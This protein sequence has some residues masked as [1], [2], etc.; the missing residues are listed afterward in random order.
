MTTSLAI[1]GS[2]Y[3]EEDAGLSFFNSIKTICTHLKELI[4]EEY[5]I[6]GDK[7]NITT[8]VFL[9]KQRIRKFN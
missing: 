7:V 1:R 4:I 8:E 3:S 9:Y 2:L 6:N 5:Y